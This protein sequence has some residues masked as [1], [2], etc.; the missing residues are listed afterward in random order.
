[1]TKTLMV[2][3]EIS[4]SEIEIVKLLSEGLTVREIAEKRKINVRTMEGAVDRMRGEYGAKNITHLVSIFF[5][6]KFL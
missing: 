3:Q 5:K 2:K 6:N 1:M 4:D